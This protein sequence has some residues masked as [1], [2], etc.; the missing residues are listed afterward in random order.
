MLPDF[1]TSSCT[2]EPCRISNHRERVDLPMMIW[3]T[4][5]ACA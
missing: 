4:L 3:V 2:T 5:F 1:R